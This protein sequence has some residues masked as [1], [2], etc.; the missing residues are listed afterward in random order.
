MSVELATSRD[1]VAARDVLPRGDDHPVCGSELDSI[2]TE[3]VHAS[4]LFPVRGARETDARSH[5][6]YQDRGVGTLVA[7]EHRHTPARQLVERV[8]DGGEA[9]LCVIAERNGHHG[10]TFADSL[11]DESEREQMSPIDYDDSWPRPGGPNPHSGVLHAS[12][13]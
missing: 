9:Q 7:D 2:V 3:L 13:D 11:D 8:G 12:G 1:A 10:E 6:R 5:F 4:L